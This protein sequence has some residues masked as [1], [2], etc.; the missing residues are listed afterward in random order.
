MFLPHVFGLNFSHRYEQEAE[1]ELDIELN[2]EEPAFLAG[3]TAMAQ[4]FSP[5]KVRY[6]PPPVSSLVIIFDLKMTAFC[7]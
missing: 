6:F 2:E 3:Q 1:E 7:S 5:I 4:T